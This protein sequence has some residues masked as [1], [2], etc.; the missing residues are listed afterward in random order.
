[1][2]TLLS[3]HLC[4]LALLGLACAHPGAAPPSRDTAK[5]AYSLGYGIATRLGPFDLEPDEVDALLLGVRDGVAGRDSRVDMREWGSGEKVHDLLLARAAARA[6]PE[7]RASQAWLDEVAKRPGVRRTSSGLLYL[8]TS[9]GSGAAPTT[10]DD[11][12]VHYK[13][14]LR[15]GSVF[16]DSHD[17]GAPEHYP[18][19]GLIPCWTEALQLMKAGGKATLWCPASLA[20]KDTGSGAKIPP[21]AALR[22]DVELLEVTPH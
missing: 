4:A 8:E 6:E 19:T 2:R 18:M 15:D 11:V 3:G 9:A 10:S 1:M 20:Y 14:T 13:G 7:R 5:T 12:V 17:K 16:E 22:Y 21:G